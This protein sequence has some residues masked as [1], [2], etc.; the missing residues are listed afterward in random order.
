M[1]LWITP[2]AGSGSALYFSNTLT[3]PVAVAVLVQAFL[4]AMW[5]GGRIASV[6]L[7]GSMAI[8]FL[9]RT[10]FT[11]RIG[12]VNGD[13]LGTTEQLVETFCLIVYTCRPCTL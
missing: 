7:G 12:G 2:A 9:A 6:L 10:Y 3:T 1:L 5:P 8:V 13:C 11:R 4:F